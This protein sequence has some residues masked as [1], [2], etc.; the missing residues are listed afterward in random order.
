MG[1]MPACQNSTSKRCEKSIRGNKVKDRHADM[2]VKNAGV[3]N[4]SSSLQN[5]S[6][7]TFK[8]N[9]SHPSQLQID[10]HVQPPKVTSFAEL[11]I[12][13]AM[14]T[15]RGRLRTVADGCEH[16]GNVERT[17]PPPPDPQSETGTLATHSGKM[18][19]DKFVS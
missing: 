17:H 9:Q 11:A 3:S 8:R 19:R 16:I 15:W 14:A 12:G 2:L 4:T 10:G 7:D 6:C 5:T 13:T 1:E 18:Y